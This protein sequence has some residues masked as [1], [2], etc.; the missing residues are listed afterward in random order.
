[1]MEDMIMMKAAVAKP[2]L[3]KLVDE[4]VAQA[5]FDCEDF[6]EWVGEFQDWLEDREPTA[7]AST[8]TG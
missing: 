8:E 5:E 7:E 4:F 2:Q 3:I 1:M 6:N